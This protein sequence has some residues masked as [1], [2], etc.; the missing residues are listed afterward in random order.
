MESLKQDGDNFEGTISI[1]RCNR[2]Y[3][4]IRLRD[5]DSRSEFVDVRMSAEDFGSC[6][7][8]MSEMTIVG[9]V[10]GLAN[11]GKVRVYEKRQA[12]YEGNSNDKVML[13]KWLT[14]NKQEEGWTISAYL[15]SQNS[16]V[17]TIHGTLVNYSATKY[18]TKD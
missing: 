7:T 5:T 13:S 11:V 14:D 3:I 17:Q 12:L 4:N 16:I 18:I 8:G 10:R 9:E 15:G 1:S 6:V 2:G